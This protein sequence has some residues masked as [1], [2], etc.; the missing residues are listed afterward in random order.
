V[1]DG[2]Y[3]PSPGPGRFL[4]EPPHRHATTDTHTGCHDHR[5]AV[6]DAR[7][8]HIHANADILAAGRTER[9]WLYRWSEGAPE[10]TM[11]AERVDAAA[12]RLG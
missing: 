10:P 9:Q 5:Y 7:R 3:V 1:S 2:I 11:L 12:W 6:G 8:P 4:H